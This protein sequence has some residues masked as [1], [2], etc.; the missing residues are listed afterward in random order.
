MT[1]FIT[2]IELILDYGLGI[3][4]VESGQGETTQIR[5]NE[6]LIRLDPSDSQEKNIVLLTT[7]LVKQTSLV[8]IRYILEEPLEKAIDLNL[9]KNLLKEVKNEKVL[10]WYLKNEYLPTTESSNEIKEWN[11]KIVEIDERGLFTRLLLVELD[12]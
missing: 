4:W 7:A 1:P 12:T 8:G 5:E 11:N 9:V 3:Q 10:D 6:L 2:F